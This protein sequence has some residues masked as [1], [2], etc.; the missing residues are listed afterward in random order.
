VSNRGNIRNQQKEDKADERLTTK[1]FIEPFT[2][3]PVEERKK[4]A[5]LRAA[6]ESR[7]VGR[8]L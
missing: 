5:P 4:A 1:E 8:T 6:G 7:V 2:G 3:K